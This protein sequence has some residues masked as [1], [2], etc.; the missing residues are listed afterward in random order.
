MT[1]RPPRHQRFF[2]A[3]AREFGLLG[4][5]LL[6]G[7]AAG[8][9]ALFLFAELSEEVLEQETQHLDE[10]VLGLLQRAQSPEMDQFARFVSFFGFEAAIA[11]IVA[12][13]VYFVWRRRW[14]TAAQLLMVTL[15][16]A[17]L[18]SLLK[19][20]FQRTRPAPVPGDF[21]GQIFSFPSGHAMLAAA[22]YLFVSYLAWRT[23]KGWPRWFG[24]GVPLALILLIGW[25]RL[26][27]GVHYL[28]DVAAGYLAGFIW[29]DAVIISFA[30]FRRRRLRR[31]NRPFP[32]HRRQDG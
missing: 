17:L 19:G 20:L 8:A 21:L 25:S 11:L 32:A 6:L 24:A 28:T 16:A 15:G 30:Y 2:A 26:Y 4:L 29:T 18:N 9:L 23:L 27:L 1:P 14:T 22:F 7:L 5:R 12:L 13:L 10:A 3:A 31:L